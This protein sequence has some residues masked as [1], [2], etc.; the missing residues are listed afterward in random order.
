[1]VDLLD[2]RTILETCE[3]DK[4]KEIEMKRSNSYGEAAFPFA[5]GLQLPG[6]R[7]EVTPLTDLQ[8]ETSTRT[9]NNTK[10]VAKLQTDSK[11]GFVPACPTS[12]RIRTYGTAPCPVGRD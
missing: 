7:D 6:W 1:M 4:S 10:V 11:H 2:S 12:V 5:P 9:I 8:R 3:V